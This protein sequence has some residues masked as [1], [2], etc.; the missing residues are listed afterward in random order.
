MNLKWVRRNMALAKHIATWSAEDKKVGAVITTQDNRVVSTGHNG[1]PNGINDYSEVS[2][3][4]MSKVHAEANAITNM[5]FNPRDLIMYVTMHPCSTCASLIIQAGFVRVISPG[6]TKGTKWTESMENAAEL[7]KQAK[8]KHTGIG[9][10][11][12][13]CPFTIF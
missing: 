2:Q 4:I 10:L 8:I 9:S 1:L 6:V 13:P 12:I 7:F 3:K 5:V 11:I